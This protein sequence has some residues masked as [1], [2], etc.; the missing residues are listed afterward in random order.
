L[1]FKRENKARKKAERR[2]MK[3]NKAKPKDVAGQQGGFTNPFLRY[4]DRKE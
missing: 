1:R 4:S 3:T 2:E